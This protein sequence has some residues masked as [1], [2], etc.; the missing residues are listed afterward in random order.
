MLKLPKRSI[1]I[2]SERN[3]KER[4]LSISGRSVFLAAQVRFRL[5][6][7]EFMVMEDCDNEIEE[8]ENR[9]LRN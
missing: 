1:E 7:Y 5:K 2:Q 6:K 3:L 8:A 9:I 4:K